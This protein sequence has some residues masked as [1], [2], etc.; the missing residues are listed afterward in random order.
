MDSEARVAHPHLPRRI[1]ALVAG[2]ACTSV[3]MTLY[4]ALWHADVPQH[5]MHH[6]ILLAMG[7][8]AFSIP[9]ATVWV[10]A[11]SLDRA[12]TFRGF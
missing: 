9:C 5:W 4:A 11:H 10:M 3:W 6:A 12:R 2:L 8:A 7:I 1:L